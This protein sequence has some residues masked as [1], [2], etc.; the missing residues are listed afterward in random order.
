MYAVAAADV[1]VGIFADYKNEK[2][3][4]QQSKLHPLDAIEI[5]RVFVCTSVMYVW[6]HEVVS[7]IAAP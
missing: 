7:I 6:R 4:K 3:N 5:R 2:K 1:T